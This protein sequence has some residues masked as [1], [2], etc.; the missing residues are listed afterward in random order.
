MLQFYPVGQLPVGELPVDDSA[1]GELTAP[2]IAWKPP[3]PRP[4]IPRGLSW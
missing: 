4:V 2:V 3:P 1:V